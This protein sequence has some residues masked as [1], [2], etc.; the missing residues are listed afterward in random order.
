MSKLRSCLRS[1]EGVKCVLLATGNPGGPGHQAAKQ[2]WVDP[3]AA[4]MR[5]ITDPET[6]EIRVFIPSRLKDDLPLIRNDPGYERAPADDAGRQT[7]REGVAL[8]RLGLHLRWLHRRPVGSVAARAGAL[9][10][11]AGLDLPPVIRLGQQRPSAIPMWA[12]SDGTPVREMGGFVFPRGSMILFSESYTVKDAGGNVK[13]NEG[14]RLTS[15]AM[16]RGI[17]ERSRG[18]TWSGWVVDPA[19]FTEVGRESIYAEIRKATAG[20]GQVLNVGRGPDRGL[21]EDAR[22][23]RERRRDEAGEARHVGIH[24]LRQLPAHGPYPAGAIAE[25]G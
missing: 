8:R 5:P 18:R 4:G 25:F 24:P 23:H 20:K 2:R 14:L 21:A 16:G 6:G 11:P 10:D 15:R 7:T 1:S 9:H 22:N 19:I 12:I 17:A 13:P 3:A